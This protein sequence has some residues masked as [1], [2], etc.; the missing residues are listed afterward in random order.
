M[1]ESVEVFVGQ[2]EDGLRSWVFDSTMQEA[3]LM[4]AL[5]KRDATEKLLA[6]NL[7]L[8][9]QA[10]LIMMRRLKPYAKRR[11]EGERKWLFFTFV[12]DCGMALERE[13]EF[14]VSAFK[15][16]VG[17]LLGKASVQA[18]AVLE[19]QALTDF[20]A[21]GKGGSL[22]LHAHAIGWSD[23]PVSHTALKKQLLEVGWLESMLKAETVVV[24]PL[25]GSWGELAWRCYYMFKAPRSAKRVRWDSGK[26]SPH[27]AFDPVI[28]RPDV[29]VRL[30]EGLSQL[31]LTEMVFAVGKD[32]TALRRQWRQDLAR[33]ADAQKRRHPWEYS[34]AKLWK[35]LRVLNNKKSKR[36]PFKFLASGKR[37][38]PTEWQKAAKERLVKL[39][40]KRKA[41][42][43][44]KVAS[45]AVDPDLDDL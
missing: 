33:W 40:T 36:L 38:F 12:G 19:I 16:K 2:L 44:S 3:E 31:E 17:K 35:R 9:R 4:R 13:P 18:I 24:R 20:P 11:P 43:S 10:F 39:S 22:M 29:A 21:G 28:V 41:Y 5:G 1:D 30:A 26:P 14:Y 7:Q 23:T 37:T 45:P 15:R 8:R 27:I 6:S 25:N 42:T 34:T 32:A